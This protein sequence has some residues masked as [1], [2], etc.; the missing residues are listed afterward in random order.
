[1]AI[2]SRSSKFIENKKG[3]LDRYYQRGDFDERFWTARD[4]VVGSP[5]RRRHLWALSRTG[6]RRGEC[7]S[8]SEET[9]MRRTG[10]R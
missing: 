4:I 9:C 7:P 3:T 5:Q 6:S 8:G 2:S 1:M 10:G